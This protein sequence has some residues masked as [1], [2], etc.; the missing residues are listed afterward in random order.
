MG[1]V[2]EPK[3]MG[4]R[5]ALK[6]IAILLG[7]IFWGLIWGI[8]GMFLSTPLMVVLRMLSAHFN[9]S[10]GFERLLATETT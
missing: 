7:L 9:V 5:L 1:Q 2:L 8:P 10:R 6:P 3:L 4:A